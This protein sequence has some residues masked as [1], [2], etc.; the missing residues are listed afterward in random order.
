MQINKFLS[1]VSYFTYDFIFGPKMEILNDEIKIVNWL[2]QN[3]KDKEAPCNYDIIYNSEYSQEYFDHFF[4]GIFSKEVDK[5]KNIEELFLRCNLFLVN[6]D[7]DLNLSHMNLHQIPLKFQHVKGNFNVSHNHL[8]DMKSFPAY[9]EKDC[10]IS[11]NKIMEYSSIKIIEGILQSQNN[12]FKNKK[13]IPENKLYWQNNVK[14]I[15]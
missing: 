13:N 2:Y 14:K 7:G 5:N 12:L 9:I 8:K 15:I 4:M 1:K 6:V 3:N 10:D 11:N